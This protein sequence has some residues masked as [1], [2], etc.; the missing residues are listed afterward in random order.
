VPRALVFHRTIVP[1]ANR[2]RY[3]EALQRRRAHFER[4]GCR[5]WVFEEAGLPGAF[6]EF[7]E[8]NERAA[9]ASAIAAAPESP[10]D[11]NRVYVEVPIA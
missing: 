4:H 6:I 3:M 9:L 10:L 8:A 11:A 2:S 5:F 7:M 1:A